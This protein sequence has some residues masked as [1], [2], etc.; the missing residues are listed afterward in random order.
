MRI[1]GR[2]TWIALIVLCG[3]AQ[4]FAFDAF[5]TIRDGY[6][7]DPSTGKPWVPH[8]IA[9][10]TWNRP[11]GVWQTH[12]QI[13]YDLDEMVK[14][15]ANSIRVDFVWQH[16]EE[17]G[18]N[19]WSWD[20]YDYLVQAAEARGIRI[21]ALIGYQWPPNWFPDEW[22]TMHPP[23]YDSGG[24]YHPV[25]W[26]SDIIN[27]EHPQA[28]E[29]YK[30]WFQNV[31]GRYATNKAI[32]GWIIGNE[33]GYLGLWSGLLDGYDPWC[34]QAFRDW[35][36]RKYTNVAA[37]NAVWGT[38]YTN[39]S[40]LSFP[41]QYRAYGVEGAIWADAVQWRED[42]IASFTAVG[43][44]AAKQADT[45]HL[46]SYSTVGMQ[47]GEEDWRYHAEDRGKIT[48]A[49]AA[50]NAPVNF[51]SVNN[52][53]WS[54][55]GHESQNG[56][57][58][59]SYTKKVS[60]IPVL[61]SETG[62]TSSETMWPGMTELRQGPLTRNALWES[63]EAG[64]IGT[65]IFA[66]HDRPYITDR[67]KGFGILYAN[68]VIKPAYW[69]ARDTYNLMEQIDI[70]DLLRGSTD[71][72]PDIAF[73]WTAAND[74]Q[75]NR[76]ECEMQQIAG[77]LERLGY[78]P[79]FM[80]LEDLG[81]G[82][83]T[84]YKVVILPRNMRVD[85]QVPGSGGK[86]V[87]EFL[88]TV[89]ISNGV[90]VVATGDLPGMQDPNG[91]AMTNFLDQVR[92]LF[93]VDATDIGGFEVPQRTKEY[94]SWYWS[95]VEVRFNTNALAPLTNGYHYKPYTWKYSDEITVSTGGTLWAEMD[96]QRN[97]SF[98][99]GPYSST[100]LPE[101]DG[102]WGTITNEDHWGWAM[103]GTNM[104]HFWG[105]SGMWQDFAVV[106]F[107]RYTVST[108]LR[109]NHD[110]PLRGGAYALIAIEWLDKG[111]TNLGTNVSTILTSGTPGDSWV[112]HKVDAIAP[113]NAWTARRII[114]SGSSTNCPN[115]LSNGGLL[116]SGSAPTGW[117]A[118]NTNNFD[119]DTGTYRTASPAWAFW[120][121][122]GIFQDATSGFA[123]GDRVKFG[124][125]LYTPSWDKL[126]GGDKNGSIQLEIYS[127][128]TLMTTLSA[129]PTITSNSPSDT[130]IYT[131]GTGAVP[132]GATALRVV[133]RSG[134]TGGD[135][136]FLVDDV[137]VY[138]T[139]PGGAVYA[140]GKQ[141]SPAVVTKNHGAAKAAIFLY[142]AGDFKPD[143]NEDSQPDVLPWQW[144]YDVF[145]SM[146]SNYFKVAP[147]LRV[148]GTNAY[149]CLAEYR[150]CTNG[151]ILMQVKNYQY[152]TNQVN[153]GPN[154][155]F[156]I[157]SSLVTGKTIRA[158]DQ[159][160][161]IETNSDGVFSISL[162]PDGQE[163]ILAYSPALITNNVICQIADAPSAIHPFGDQCYGITVKF[164]PAGKTNVTV[165][166]AFMEDGDNGD[167]VSNEIYQVLYTNFISTAGQQTFW[168]WIP[169][170]D[171]K[172]SDYIS[173]ADGGN[174]K[175]VA[176]V[177]DSSSN[178]IAQ[179]VSTTT[180]LKW[181]LAPTTTNVPVLLQ[182][183]SVTNMTV[184]WEDLTE[185]LEWQN[186]PLTRNN[187]FP[188][189]VALFRSTKTQALYT[190]H[191]DRVNHVA[192][193]LEGL[194]YE[195]GNDLDLGFDNVTVSLATDA[196]NGGLVTAYAESVESGTNGWTAD[197]LWHVARDLAYGGTNSWGYNNG[198]NY[199][200][201]ARNSGTLLSP[202]ISLGSAS[203]A[204]LTFKSWHETEDAGT[205]WDRKQVYVSAD[206][207]NWT[208]LLQ[209]SGTNQQ[210][211][212]QSQDLTAYAG[213][214]I[215]LK[216]HFDTI[217]ALKNGYRGWYLDDIEIKVVESTAAVHFEDDMT[218]TTNWTAG[219]FW[220]LTTN[221]SSS[222]TTSWVY[223]DG[224]DYD[225]GRRNSG[226]LLSRWID[227]S[228]VANA[229]LSFK[230]WYRTEDSGVS[231]DRKLVKL[232]TDGT[233]WTTILQV[234]GPTQE[235]TTQTYD[236]SAYAGRSIRLQFFFDTIDAFNN[237]FEDWY[238][239][240]VRVS[241]VGGTG[242]SVF[243]DSAEAG[244][245]GW[246]FSGLWRLAPD[247]YY[248]A[249]HGWIY[250]NGTN[251]ST[252]ARNSGALISPWI[253][254][255]LA[256]GATL[257]FRSWYETE[258]TG[259][260]W[261]RKIVYATTDGSNWVQLVQ[262]SGLNKQWVPVT[263]DLGAFVGQRIRLKFFFDTIDA[264]YNNFFGWG[265][266]DVEVT[267]AGTNTIFSETFD[268]ADI[269]ATWSRAAGAGNWSSTGGVLRAWRI[270]NDDNIVYAGNAS[271]SNVVVSADLRYNEQG[272]Y[273]ND[274]ELYVRYQNRDN[275]V[276]VG[277]RNFYGFWRLKYTVRKDTN[278][279]AEGWLYDFAKTNQPVADTW[280]NLRVRADGTNFLVYLDGEH[281]GSFSTTN[282]PTGR[283]GLGARAVQLGIWEPA[284]GYFFIDDDEYSYY[285]PN[286]GAIVTL[287]SPLNLD[288]GYLVR[289]FP[290]L[291]LP[292]T[293]VMSDAEVSN[294][295]TWIT[296]GFYGLLAMDGGVAMKNETGAD[297]PGRIENL[298][299]VA[300]TLHSVTGAGALEIGTNVH[301]VTL[302][303]N[304]E[305]F[306][307][308]SGSAAAWSTM[309]D[310]LNLGSTD[311]GTS[312]VPSLVCN[313][314]T[315]KPASPPKTFC[316]NYAV[317][318]GGQLT[319]ESRLVAQ[320]AFEW[321]QSQTY[322]MTLEL[323]AVRDPT[324]PNLD[325]VVFQTN[326]WTLN[327]WGTNNLNIVVPTENV[328]TGTNL[329]W[330][331]YCYPWTAT[332][333]WLSHKGFFS[334][335]NEGLFVTLTGFGLQVLGI[336]E[337]AFAG[338]D[339]DMWVAYNTEGSNFL[340]HFGIKDYG[341]LR[342]EDTFND[343]DYNG[344][345]I[346]EDS[347]NIAWKVT[348]QVLRATV[349]GTGG[350]EYVTRDGLAVTGRNITV[351]YDVRF[352]GGATNAADGG[353]IY[354]GRLLYVNPSAAGWA[355]TNVVYYTNSLPST[356]AW[357]HIMVHV[358]DG[359]PFLRSD[360]YVDNIPV[361]LS[362][363]LE[364]TNWTS[365]SV[366]LLSP[367]YGG[368]VE[369]DNV[370]VVD[371]EYSLTT[372][373]V[374]GFVI[375]TNANFWP[376]LP[377][378]DPDMWEL[379][380]STAGGRYDWYIFFKGA[381]THGRQEGKVYF[382]PRLIVED[383]NFPTVSVAGNTV[384]V[385]IEWE[386]IPE[387][388]LPARLC[389]MLQNPY[390]DKNHSTNYYAIT[391][392]AGAQYFSVPIPTN[393]PYAADYSWLA[394]IFPTN[395][396]DP[397]LE[398]MGSD[399]TFRFSPQGQPVGPE[400]RIIV[401]VSTSGTFTC[402]AD[403][404]APEDSVFYTWG[405]TNNGD[406]TGIGAPDGVKCWKADVTGTTYV[407]WGLFHTNGLKDFS[408][409]NYLKF[410]VKTEEA[411]V[412]VQIE[413]PAG[414]QRT[415]YLDQ[416]GW[417][418]AKAGVWQEVT[419]P[420]TNF[421]F[422]SPL[423]NV[424]GSFLTTLEYLP[425]VRYSLKSLGSAKT[426]VVGDDGLT[427]H[428]LNIK[429]TTNNGA[430]WGGY[431]P[432]NFTASTW[433]NVE[434]T[435]ATNGWVVGG[436]NTIVGTTNGGASWV[437][438]T[439]GL[440]TN[441]YWY[442]LDFIN[443]KTGWACGTTSI[444][445]TTDGGLT[446]TSQFG[447][448]STVRA[449]RFRD[450]NSGWACGQNLLLWTTNGG[451]MWTYA[452][453]PAPGVYWRDMFFVNS[454]TGWACG[455]SGLVC[456]S[457]D[458]GKTWSL[459][460]GVPAASNQYLYTMT[461]SDETN[462]WIAGSGVSTNNMFFTHDGG[463]TWSTADSGLSATLLDVEFSDANH[464]YAVGQSVY[465]MKT[466]NGASATPVWTNTLPEART[467][468]IDNVRWSITP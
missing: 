25:R 100:N 378:Y 265:I 372:Q 424:Y 246:S 166:I 431:Q 39:F 155:T 200:T 87:L 181:G 168:M 158:L 260:S 457:T 133:V 419:I 318:A 196:T 238:V 292:S 344:W 55:L 150:T 320:R 330:V 141:W 232:S 258:D 353:V 363:P 129:S 392:S 142:G 183:G 335:G 401:Y 285:S 278:Y 450:A 206:G 177:E 95:P 167:G 60:G 385:P 438:M 436:Y 458:A 237:Q 65:H 448:S 414:T 295:C 30:E 35:S 14:M 463:S 173:T 208:R 80:N 64:A 223:N 256:D 83:Y 229:K 128:A 316:F 322:K 118:W 132:A 350:Y 428:G 7:F 203:A 84:N 69:V 45:N 169:D 248:S 62:F 20:N 74:S 182:K 230:S 257:T 205:S 216:F 85:L 191:F 13:D 314:L 194:G 464:G 109:S 393:T 259:T 107:G 277:I 44:V 143:G 340:T 89:V 284:Q 5:I 327:G 178:V 48:Q 172:D 418:P 266:D 391:N 264:V 40:Q 352:M 67:E 91:R 400:T 273:F 279:V 124:G 77:A 417:V 53:P 156:T 104:I 90:H 146:I 244:V 444:V 34:E 119:P 446:W 213:R 294:V 365:A 88:R 455:Y 101:W 407:G 339:W 217:D 261:D 302:D 21:F 116:G 160:Y 243:S 250:N 38:S 268:A 331:M 307:A 111:G 186:T 399:D 421:G 102:I 398:R 420:L 147:G 389:V 176:W 61:Y 435:D 468:Y 402:Y 403:S 356:G 337:A 315:N 105:D 325:V 441:N 396:A 24:I 225:N 249:G 370:R 447:A 379:D 269:S 333:A 254:L 296:N 319:N 359:E 137:F 46:L 151:S 317:D 231:W 462:G 311:Y 9:Y 367:Y 144:R 290:T 187:A 197:G 127:N 153:G 41:D 211:V 253:D 374:S 382:A 134:G 110:D 425:S 175:F 362:E 276:K 47:W 202:W 72:R 373:M 154:M 59:I 228:G 439:R 130:W 93:G 286:E 355:D 222:A 366:G 270:G 125:Y 360:L 138:D 152:D 234:S 305:E 114:R 19:Q 227:L 36:Q 460:G 342:N 347:T 348:N 262:V 466:T 50:S 136:R 121:D 255:A 429:S 274:A 411:T 384:W 422:A 210:W 334:S 404:G 215:R 341:S 112:Q 252:G 162:P 397:W 1:Q 66:W 220:R 190:N 310:A 293:Y 395:A 409:Y 298:F 163:M 174:Y 115:L 106:P 368:Y 338:R 51:F 8:G 209:V 184:E 303:Y 170:P 199:S 280:Y 376:S 432:T 226:S 71:P 405:G 148:L 240:D 179:S 56:Q 440:P 81:A 361:F 434:F 454:S 165:K 198:T 328:M 26:Q 297:D 354:Q 239:D 381:N 123:G 251:Y 193:W 29:Q 97:K 31:C 212:T 131:E 49:C 275:Y 271:W 126:R 161:I 309:R 78:E 28:R 159:A 188:N 332:N 201:G 349:V 10:Q 445:V 68:R 380:G 452:A 16:I 386:H 171:L 377:D 3:C 140:D 461:W 299:G 412:K 433:Y 235:W 57:W 449:I 224:V 94:V 42:S 98:E 426:W 427:G 117:S 241:S 113:S 312:T 326:F 358:R 383:T 192:D 103:D 357:H 135:G 351:E 287:G 263:R 281:V 52:Y 120:W 96:S 233:N 387:S 291:I 406:Y 86:G 207:T 430:Q 247:F 346:T 336:T 289:F 11:L 324:N 267:I 443:S 459:A 413:A 437:P 218:A 369:W 17:N 288:W 23:E 453:V 416:E 92:D 157:A 423:T 272:P 465:I 33:S 63:L 300:P 451:A 145:G 343:G 245:N 313:V 185:Q 122:S 308:V 204:T 27:Y 390:T 195:P 6:F 76:Y 99:K 4:A 214:S 364:V 18:D 12:E 15:G 236:L 371:E 306:V 32:V 22:Y 108:Y 54:I 442:S 321:I 283:V 189:R 394:Y 329:Y 467:F 410:W 73:L 58:G 301:Y 242:T 323:K 149:L 282:F 82:A 70:Q 139:T 345:T 456:R 164:D 37:A 43:A 2:W 79:W 375:P 415:R 75:Y 180:Q 304:P 388:N 219:G 408:Q 221:R